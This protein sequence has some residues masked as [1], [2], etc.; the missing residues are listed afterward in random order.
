MTKYKVNLSTEKE[1]EII[2]EAESED[3]IF[4]LLDNGDLFEK[5]ISEKETFYGDS[6]WKIWQVEEL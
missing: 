1:N 2:V 5:A 4:K 3:E 6:S